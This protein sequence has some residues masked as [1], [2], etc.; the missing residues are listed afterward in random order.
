MFDAVLYP[1]SLEDPKISAA[2]SLKAFYISMLVFVV[3]LIKITAL[4]IYVDQSNIIP[5]QWLDSVY[6]TCPVF[7][8]A[9]LF[10][11]ASLS[12][13]GY[14]FA[15]PCFYFWNWRAHEQ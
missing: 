4:Y 8:K 5:Q 15:L 7:K 1:S 12:H 14:L 6:S 2:R 9:N 3:F 13:T 10:H 11:H